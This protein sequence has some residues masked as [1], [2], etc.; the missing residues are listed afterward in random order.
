MSVLEGLQVL[1]HHGFWNADAQV[2]Q[3]FRQSLCWVVGLL[4]ME[5]A[6]SLIGDFQTMQ[7]R[8]REDLQ[9]ETD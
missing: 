6:K 8:L 9:K 2:L 1:L 4:V 3:H 5:C 7:W